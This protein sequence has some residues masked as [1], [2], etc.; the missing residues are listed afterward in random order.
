MLNVFPVFSIYFPTNTLD[1]MPINAFDMSAAFAFDVTTQDD[2][3][4]AIGLPMKMAITKLFHHMCKDVISGG[5][6]V[7]SDPPAQPAATVM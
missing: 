1:Y 2:G 4:H 6:R 3:M 5:H 7:G